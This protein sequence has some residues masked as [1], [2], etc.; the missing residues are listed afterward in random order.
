MSKEEVFSL[1]AEKRKELDKPLEVDPRIAHCQE[2]ADEH[3]FITTDEFSK[4]DVYDLLFVLMPI[5]LNTKDIET[6]NHIAEI[7]MNFLYHCS[8][9][10]VIS[11]VNVMAD[12]YTSGEIEKV[13]CFLNAGSE[14]EASKILDTIE[15]LDRDYISSLRQKQGYD[16]E[17]EACGDF[18][19]LLHVL[20]NHENAFMDVL[21]LVAAHK[22]V[23]EKFEMV[24]SIIEKHKDVG[25]SRNRRKVAEKYKKQM[26]KLDYALGIANKATSFVNE[27]NLKQ[28]KLKRSN[29]I[30]RSKLDS[31]EK[32]LRSDL[33]KDCEI[34]NV[35][36]IVN[37]IV[38]YPD[39]AYAVLLLIQ[40]HNRAYL[41]K[42]NSEYN[43]LSS[44]SEVNYK[45]L[46][47][48]FG[49]KSKEYDISKVMHLKL[50]D[51][52]SILEVLI[53]RLSFTE[54]KVLKILETSNLE[55]IE[56]IS[57]Y[58]SN[59]Y[60][61]IDY[62]S[63]NIDL[64]NLN[65]TDIEV[66]GNNI[67]LLKSYSV[68][69]YMFKNS[70]EV[71]FGDSNLLNINLQILKEYDLIKYFKTTDN[72]M[73]LLN[74][75]ISNIIDK[76]LELGYEV[77]LKE[78]LGILNFKNLKRLDVIH[79]LNI[80]VD[81]VE[82]LQELLESKRFFMSDNDIDSYLLNAVDYHEKKKFNISLDELSN[83]KV[84]NRCYS[85]DG[86]LVSIQKV[87]RLLQDGYSLYDAIFSGM[88]VSEDEYRRVID[89]FN[90]KEYMLY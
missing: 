70:M 43:L 47:H 41:D 9:E 62:V 2:W 46:L 24:D 26:F 85:F 4:I 10:E 37:G 88:N 81:S 54:D 39:L 45:A 17:E 79:M 50:D 52:K 66:L 48:E 22:C 61:S 16:L 53:R 13:I 73:F 84:S 82:E 34:S 72:F 20:N 89:F 71:L 58:I 28:K 42:L 69:P 63:N 83:Y 27:C 44:N 32:V 60:I 6:S 35:S 40:E 18:A 14:E 29:E 8:T 55:R 87:N 21:L 1:I 57:K 7:F 90:Q 68:N 56:L 3:K 12:M 86:V 33:E 67:E 51:I 11:F 23:C 38:E 49:I 76:Y 31:L 80:P 64:Y 78:D 15:E 25:K 30:K 59:G 77:L 19:T 74:S 5:L 36:D 75:N 65:S